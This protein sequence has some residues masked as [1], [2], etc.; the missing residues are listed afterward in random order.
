MDITTYRHKVNAAMES[1]HQMHAQ[2]CA[3]MDEIGGDAGTA[4]WNALYC[5]MQTLGGAL[6]MLDGHRRDYYDADGAFQRPTALTPDAPPAP[7]PD[8]D[9]EV[10]K[11]YLARL[12]RFDN[13]DA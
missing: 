13:R 3:L 4:E 1:G 7:D 8:S 9:P 2:L 10:I 6:S 11:A 12:D 5:A